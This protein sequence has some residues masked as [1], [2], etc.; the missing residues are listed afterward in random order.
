MGISDPTSTPGVRSVI[1]TMTP[2]QP[3]KFAE[4]VESELEIN[5]FIKLASNENPY[6]PYPRSIES[7]QRELLNLN[8][9][10]NSS[11]KRLRSALGHLHQVSPNCICLSHGAEGMLQT[12]GKCFIER[13][14]EV[15]VPYVTYGL[16]TDITKVMG[17]RV[18]EATMKSDAIDLN[19]IQE[20]LG[21]KTKLVWLANPNNPTG[22]IVNRAAF[23]D[24]LD[25][26]PK[27]AWIVLDEAYAEFADEAL[28]PDRAALITE[29]RRI[30]SVRTFSKAYGLAGARLGY[31][32]ASEE[33]VTILDTVSEP[34]NANRVAL[35]GGLAAIQE[36]DYAYQAAVGLIKTDRHMT[37]QKLKNFG[38]RVIPSHA[39][40]VMFE[41][42]LKSP[43]MFDRLLHRGIITRSGD[44]WGCENMI[45]VSVGKT[46]QMERFIDAVGDILKE[47]E[48]SKFFGIQ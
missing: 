47:L 44:I 31:A 37:T 39:N 20:L 35:A 24:L 3:G 1:R 46:D 28:L 23:L 13:G 2:Y 19:A 36:D 5:E 18:I 4:D 26:M 9:Y 32:I 45:R 48:G 30:I 21:P 34:F 14:D 29:G 25:A 27:N 11:F 15:I 22:T 10:P 7:M 16:Y 8:Q 6:G 41:T 42:P 43:I 40:F 12:I 17:G 33:M 38:L